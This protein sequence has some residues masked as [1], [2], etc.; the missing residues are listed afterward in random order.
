MAVSEWCTLDIELFENL[1]IYD[2]EAE[3][4]T[5]RTTNERKGKRNTEDTTDLNIQIK[6]D[7]IS[8]REDQ[9]RMMRENIKTKP[10]IKLSEEQEKEHRSRPKFAWS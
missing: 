5:T 9:E 8:F 3:A 1:T 6:N 7:M 10:K 4:D 2:E